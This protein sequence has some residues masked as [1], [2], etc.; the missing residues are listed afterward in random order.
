M[1]Y[2]VLYEKYFCQRIFDFYAWGISLMP[3]GLLAMP[4][5]KITPD[6]SFN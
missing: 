2:H 6:G 5:L 1:K 3:F 4:P